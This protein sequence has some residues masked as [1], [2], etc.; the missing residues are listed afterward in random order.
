MEKARAIPVTVTA[1][2]GVE[3]LRTF[4][5]MD[6]WIRTEVGCRAYIQH[7]RWPNE[8]VCGRCGVVGES[9]VTPCGMF[10][11][12]ACDGSTS[13]TAS[14]VLQD[15]RKPLRTWFLAMR[16]IFSQ[17]NG[18]SAQGLQRV[19]GLGSIAPVPYISIVHGKRA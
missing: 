5:E 3:Y 14:M 15:T 12:K 13:L 6:E 4:D 16:F 11:S 19:L 9:R 7:L 8:F 17:K 1:G 2:G 18:V 10:R